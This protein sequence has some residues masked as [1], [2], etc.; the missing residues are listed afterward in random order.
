MS[1]VER[2]CGLTTWRFSGGAQRRLEFPGKVDTE[3][4][5]MRGSNEVIHGTSTDARSPHVHAAV[6]T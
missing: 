6:Q 2:V 3:I 4:R 5:A 1:V